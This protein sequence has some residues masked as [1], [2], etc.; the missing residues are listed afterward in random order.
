MAT[1]DVGLRTATIILV[2]IST[3]WIATFAATASGLLGAP[4][5]AVGALAAFAASEAY[6]RITM[7]EASRP[8]R[9]LSP[10]Q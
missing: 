2:A 3:M 5:L 6:A 1:S 10:E 9:L 8:R 4:A 7:R